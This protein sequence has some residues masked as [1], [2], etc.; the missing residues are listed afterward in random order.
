VALIP[1]ATFES[2]AGTLPS[3]SVLDRLRSQG[4]DVYASDRAEPLGIVITGRDGFHITVTT[5]GVSYEVLVEPSD[6]VHYPGG[7]APGIGG[8]P[9][10]DLR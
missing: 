2:N 9:E 7:F 8:N 10:D 5:D 4:T 3:S 6:S 1:I